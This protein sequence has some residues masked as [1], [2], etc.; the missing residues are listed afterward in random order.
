[1]S[2]EFKIVIIVII[3]SIILLG[4]FLLAHNIRNIVNTQADTGEG[5]YTEEPKE[6]SFRAIVVTSSESYIEVRPIEDEDIKMLSD[7]VSIG[8]GEDNDALYFEGAELL[9][10]YT[11]EVMD[12]YPTQIKVIKIQT[13]MDYKTKI[14]DLPGDYSLEAA[15][16]DNCFVSIHGSK[17]YNKDELDRFLE[18]VEKNTPDFIRCVSFTTEGDMLIT[19]VNFEGSN[20]FR[21]CLDWTRDEY[22]ELEYRTYHYGRFAKLEINETE[23]SIGIYLNNP[24]EGDLNEICVTGYYKNERKTPEWT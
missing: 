2:K 7:R 10:T 15:I 5:I 14:E 19:D 12:S 13:E 6:A 9:I 24:I 11:G 16:E 8:L 21:T 22:S 20:S 18:N 3:T 23:E 1:M 17:I 4:A